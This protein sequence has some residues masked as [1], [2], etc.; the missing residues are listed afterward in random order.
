MAT[1]RRFFPA[2]VG[3]LWTVAL[4]AQTPDGTITGRVVDDATHAPLAGVSVFI[5]GTR[6]GTVTG[7]DG[8][9]RLSGVPAGNQ[10]VRARQIGYTPQVRNVSV[11]TG[12]TVTADFS[13]VASPSQ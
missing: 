8:S 10:A 9:F 1:V 6:R 7:S 4:G 3:I 13:L 2:L 12:A 11:G 5:E